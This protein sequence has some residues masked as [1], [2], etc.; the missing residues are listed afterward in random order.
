MVQSFMNYE[1]QLGS[2]KVPHSQGQLAQL[3]VNGA[4]CLRVTALGLMLQWC[5]NVDKGMV[6]FKVPVCLFADFLKG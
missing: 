2:I 6:G 4:A 1:L 5:A 3:E